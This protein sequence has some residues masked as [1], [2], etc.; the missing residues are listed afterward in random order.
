MND[1][2]LFLKQHVSC[3]LKLRR[4]YY[5][6]VEAGGRKLTQLGDANLVYP[7]VLYRLGETSLL[8][9]PETASEDE[10]LCEARLR[11][12]KE[13][14]LSYVIGAHL[15]EPLRC[16]IKE[17]GYILRE[18]P[19]DARVQSCDELSDSDSLPWYGR[20]MNDTD[21][22]AM[23]SQSDAEDRL[24]N[25][26]RCEYVVD[27][28]CDRQHLPTCRMMTREARH[29]RRAHIVIGYLRED[30]W[31]RKS[32]ATTNGDTRIQFEKALGEI[33]AKLGNTLNVGDVQCITDIEMNNVTV[34]RPNP[35]QSK[36]RKRRRP[37]HVPEADKDSVIIL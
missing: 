9:F 11:R 7:Y 36:S 25:F 19:G 27:A 22:L 4:V 16:D 28:A 20:E 17:H 6:T 1:S 31:C 37:D 23:D 34:S 15:S 30:M 13:K 24:W 3:L 32:S 33:R 21:S 10:M 8:V 18:C 12:R 26:M 2:S 14:E 29:S 35:H 5:V